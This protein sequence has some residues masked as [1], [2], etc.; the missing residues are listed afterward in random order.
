YVF[1]DPGSQNLFQLPNFA[2]ISEALNYD[3]FFKDL[4]N[5]V[6]FRPPP[7]SQT[8]ISRQQSASASEALKYTSVLNLLTTPGK[9]ISFLLAAAIKS[10]LGTGFRC[11]K[12][13]SIAEKSLMFGS[14]ALFSER[15]TYQRHFSTSL[16]GVRLS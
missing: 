12:P 13:A 5:F 8:T 10:R 6:V 1:N 4:S 11:S 15:R 3:T 7:T 14:P 16:S 9:E 2:A